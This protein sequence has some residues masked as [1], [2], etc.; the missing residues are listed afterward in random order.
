MFKYLFEQL[1]KI[2]LKNRYE[3]S[4][5]SIICGKYRTLLKLMTQRYVR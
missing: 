2:T 4:V 1:K 3:E 5:E